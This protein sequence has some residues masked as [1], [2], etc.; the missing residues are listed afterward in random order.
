LI[1]QVDAVSIFADRSKDLRDQNPLRNE[2][3][4]IIA[5]MKKIQ[6]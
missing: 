6:I 1:L 2:T 4:A 3:N 5:L